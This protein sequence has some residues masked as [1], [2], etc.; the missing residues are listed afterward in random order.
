MAEIAAATL[1]I[2][3]GHWIVARR[4]K[5]SA[6]EIDLIAKRGHT[7]VFVEVKARDSLNAAAHSITP[8]QR[9]RIIRAAEY[10]LAQNPSAAGA[11]LRF[12]AIL[13]GRGF[14]MRHLKDAFQ[15]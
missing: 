1:L 14:S 10:W 6:G 8:H 2:L 15:A 7:Y 9:T 11:N 13:V 5:S 12:D 3:K 4:F